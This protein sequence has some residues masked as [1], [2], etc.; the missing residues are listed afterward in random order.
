MVKIKIG[1]IQ[2]LLLSVI[3][4]IALTFPKTGLIHREKSLEELEEDG[5]VHIGI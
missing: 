5:E 4:L 3:F 2:K 1:K